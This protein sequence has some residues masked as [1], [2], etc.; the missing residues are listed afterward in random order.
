MYLRNFCREEEADPFTQLTSI[1]KFFLSIKIIGIH[2][3]FS[4]PGVSAQ[5]LDPSNETVL[6]YSDARFNCSVKT[7]GWT[8]MTWTVNERLALSI[9]EDSGPIGSPT[10]FSAKN[11]STAG[12]YKWEFLLK[13]ATTADAGKVGC[14][15][16]N[17]LPVFAALNVQRKYYLNWS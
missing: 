2:V 8:V 14:Q 4:S 7:P 12:V 17:S 16:Q 15:V 5:V 13:G 1:K 11:Y 9:T 6:Q 10:R 3:F